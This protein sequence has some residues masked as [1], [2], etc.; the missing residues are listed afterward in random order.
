M[1]FLPGGAGGAP[2]AT[3]AGAFPAW[4]GYAVLPA[5]EAE[6]ARALGSY[7]LRV[8][9]L[10]VEGLRLSECVVCAVFLVCIV[11]RWVGFSVRGV[12]WSVKAA[13]FGVWGVGCAVQGVGCRVWCP[14]C[15]V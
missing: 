1:T 14:G 10:R 4:M 15:R 9:C 8:W 12:V 2:A 11:V 5:Y 7:L 13:G 6:P 3:G